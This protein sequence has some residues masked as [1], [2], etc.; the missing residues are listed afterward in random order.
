MF[1]GCDSEQPMHDVSFLWRRYR[2]KRRGERQIDSIYDDRDESNHQGAT[3]KG[4]LA[5][6]QAIES[7][8]NKKFEKI[9]PDFLKNVVTGKNLE[10]DLYNQ[11]LGL[12]VEMN[13]R[14]HYEYVPYFH[15]NKEAFY[16]QRYRDE[17]KKMK[18]V[19]NGIKF[20]EVPYT[21]K[22][23]DVY[24]FILKKVREMGYK[25]E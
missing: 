7:I 12:C 14:Q 8:F 16:N 11:E 19:E 1:G 13:G 23:S 9:R 22:E 4:E 20:I 15:K 5:C 17:I 2:R 6:K 18:C 25:I 10:L 24:G 3:S 21:V